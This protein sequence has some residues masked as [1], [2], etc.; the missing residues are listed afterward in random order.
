MNDITQFLTGFGGLAVF[1]V[2]FADQAGLPVPAPPL[3]L[4]AG[5]LVSGRPTEPGAGGGHDGGGGASGRF[6]L[7]L[8]GP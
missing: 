4:A 8:S 2:V 5:A 3:L 7:V 1:A 6:D